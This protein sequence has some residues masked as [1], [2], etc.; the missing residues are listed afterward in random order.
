VSFVYL[1]QKMQKI[2]ISGRSRIYFTELHHIFSTGRYEC[3]MIIVI[4]SF[5]NRSRDV[6]MVT[7]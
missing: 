7:N 1:C 5:C 4:Y 3:R 6:E 2:G